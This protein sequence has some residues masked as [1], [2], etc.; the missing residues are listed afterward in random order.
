M[1][2]PQIIRVANLGQVLL[3]G[4]ILALQVAGLIRNRNGLAKTD[5]GP[6]SS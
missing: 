6:A 3:G 4:L 1:T 2:R 5:V